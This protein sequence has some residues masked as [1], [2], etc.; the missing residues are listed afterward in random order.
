[1]TINSEINS[2]SCFPDKLKIHQNGLHCG[3]RDRFTVMGGKGPWATVAHLRSCYTSTDSTR[4][5]YCC[6][7]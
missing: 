6:E 2:D 1:M 7:I 5:P 3:L 4:R